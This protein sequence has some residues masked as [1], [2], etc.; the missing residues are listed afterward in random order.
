MDLPR[1]HFKHNLHRTPPMIG[2]WLMAASPITAEAMGCAGFDWLVVDMEH[3]PLDLAAVSASLQAI[4]GTGASAVTRIPWNDTVM[5]KR[6]L[7]A[8]AQTIMFPFVQTAEEARRAVAATRYPPKGVR[9]IAAMTRAARYATVKDY[10]KRAHGEIAVVIQLE[11]PEAIA[12]MDEIAAVEGVDALFIGPGDLS[13]A[14]GHIGQIGHK[15]VQ[16]ALA[17]AASRANALGKPIG[18]VGPN[19]DMVRNFVA[20]GFNFLAIS[21]DMGFMMTQAQSWLGALRGVHVRDAENPSGPY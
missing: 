21:S 9:G 1:N 12:R 5:V 6:V 14:M 3:V 8:G 7:D 19:P 11:T 15:D 13:G 18:I 16:A 2:T 17:A 4:A 10:L 20:M